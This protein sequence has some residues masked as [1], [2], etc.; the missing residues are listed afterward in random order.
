[1]CEIAQGMVVIMPC[2]MQNLKSQSDAWKECYGS[3]GCNF[4]SMSECRISIIIRGPGA[5]NTQ[6]HLKLK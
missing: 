1:M 6:I 5:I 3:M 4:L 2:T